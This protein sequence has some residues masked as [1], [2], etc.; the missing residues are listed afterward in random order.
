M[1]FSHLCIFSFSQET[2]SKNELEL[3]RLKIDLEAA[4]EARIAWENQLNQ[5]EDTL[6]SLT[7]ENNELQTRIKD[8]EA[9]FDG[10]LKEVCREA[11]LAQGELTKLKKMIH[12]MLSALIGKKSELLTRLFLLRNLFSVV[13]PQLFFILTPFFFCNR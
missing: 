11:E 3:S 5:S 6:T 12:Q 8:M 1:Y 2:V 9:I 13:T 4:H 10:K 7:Q